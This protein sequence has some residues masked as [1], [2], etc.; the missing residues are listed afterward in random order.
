MSS[1]KSGAS[2]KRGAS[3]SKAAGANAADAAR[4]SADA[5]RGS[6]DA[7]RV[8]ADAARVSADAAQSSADIPDGPDDWDAA[9]AA[10]EAAAE[11]AGYDS[12]TAEASARPLE[13]CA[14]CYMDLPA[15][16]RCSNPFCASPICH[17][18]LDLYVSNNAERQI[19]PR[20]VG[21]TCDGLY[22]YKTLRTIT[23]P[24]AQNVLE[25]LVFGTFTASGTA[26]FQREAETRQV[27]EQTRR[28]REE[29]FRRD[30]PPAIIHCAEVVMPR[31]L[32]MV[33]TAVVRRVAKDVQDA[34]RLCMNLLCNGHLDAQNRCMLCRTRFC[35]ACERRMDDGHVCDPNDVLS[36]EALSKMTKCPSCGAAV[37]RRSGCDSM[38]CANCGTRFL[39]GSGQ[40][41]GHGGHS[42]IVQAP[43]K[44]SI[45]VAFRGDITDPLLLRLLLDF[46]AMEPVPF[47]RDVAVKAC[48][49]AY[50]ARLGVVLT[51]PDEIPSNPPYDDAVAYQLCRIY[52]MDII[53]TARTH[54]Y[55]FLAAELERHSRSKTLTVEVLRGFIV[56]LT[57]IGFV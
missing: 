11:G 46:E 55:Y 40:A 57:N 17:E 52:D 25:R 8:S 31:R 15:T 39:Y 7:A 33:Q 26:I 36:V 12:G 42:V 47:K 10:A 43:D 22:M 44:K 37:E 21:T 48:L 9:E 18:C 2:A 19:L 24:H 49:K 45:M 51:N 32:A 53:T 54:M 1:K 35:T 29:F 50:L 28:E 16:V 3:A 20:C 23:D 41:G 4:G 5:A 34:R 56:R 30:F 6:A 14:V 27:L 38:T 13:T